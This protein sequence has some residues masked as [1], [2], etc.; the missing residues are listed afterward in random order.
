MTQMPAQCP[1]CRSEMV[2]TQ[3]SCTNCE[4]AIVG[5]YSLSAFHRLPPESLRFLEDF[6][7]NRGNV[8]EMERETGESYWAIRSRLD[9]VIGQMG[10]DVPPDTE[11][12]GASRKEILARL[13]AGE[14]DVETATRLLKELGQ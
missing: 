6:I 3:L 13:R 7:R 12:A 2:V 14:I 5:H 10:F 1:A 9:K 4:T 11:A 8:K